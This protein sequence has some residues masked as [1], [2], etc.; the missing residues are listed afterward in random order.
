MDVGRAA[1]SSVWVLP[2]NTI[3]ADEVGEIGEARTQVAGSATEEQVMLSFD[4]LYQRYYPRVLA[5]LRFRIGMPDVAEDL[6]SLVFERA[7]LHFDDLQSEDAAG[8]WLFRIARNCAADYFRRRRQEASLDMLV[9]TEYSDALLATSPEEAALLSEERT[10]LL[11]HLS[12]LSE[13]ERE[14]IG[15]KFVAC[16]HN[17]DIARV[18]HIPPGTVGSILHRALGRLRDALYAERERR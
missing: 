14:V 10:L 9:D 12:H 8:A 7:L 15:L 2:T 11:A 1:I 16:L 13:R 3:K 6:T 5:F 4:E 18:L 17:C